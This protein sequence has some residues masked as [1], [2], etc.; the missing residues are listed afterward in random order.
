M[1]KYWKKRDV[2]DMLIE[3]V[4]DGVQ[5]SHFSSGY[6]IIESLAKL[7][8]VDAEEVIYCKDCIHN[9]GVRDGVPFWDEDI[10]CDYWESD[11]LQSYDY[12]SHGKRADMR[13][14]E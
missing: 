7:P 9:V 12:C 14:A 4:N 8:T 10:T 2:A 1:G 3:L 5:I 6:A 13:G 11:G